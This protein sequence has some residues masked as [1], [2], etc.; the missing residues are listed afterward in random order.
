VKEFSCN[1][2]F[3]ALYGEEFAFMNALKPFSV[4]LAEGSE[5]KLMDGVPIE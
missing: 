5:V 4:M 1:F 2:D 3:K